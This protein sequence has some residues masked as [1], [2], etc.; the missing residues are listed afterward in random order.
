[1]LTSVAHESSNFLRAT[2]TEGRLLA[3][4]VR[5]NRRFRVYSDQENLIY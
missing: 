2:V 4:R 5:S 1:M 3:F